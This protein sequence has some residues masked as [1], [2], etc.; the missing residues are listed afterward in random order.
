MDN[1]YFIFLLATVLVAVFFVIH[2][3]WSKIKRERADRAQLESEE[4]RMFGFLHLLGGVIE[5]GSTLDALH[6]VIVKG[7]AQVL[8]CQGAALYVLDESG[9]FLVPKAV[10]DNC[11]PMIGLPAE[12]LAKA[13]TDPKAIPSYVKLA[14]IPVGEGV[15]GG[16]VQA[17]DVVV[18]E[19][20]RDHPTAKD[21]LVRYQEKVKAMIVPLRI[22]G[23][24]IGLL[25]VANG[26]AGRVFTQ[27]DKD[28]F[29]SLAEQCAFAVRNAST[30]RLALEMRWMENDLKNASEV[31]R[32]LLPSGEPEIAGYRIV[33]VNSPARIISG[34]YYDF[35][36][37]EDKSLGVVIAD[38]SGKGVAAGLLMSMCRSVLRVIASA[39]KSSAATLAAVNRHIF[40][41]TKEDMFISM[42]YLKLNPENGSVE[43]ARAGHDAPYVFRAE[44]G[45]VEILKPK[46]LAVGI[47][48]GAV[49]ERV[50]QDF[51]FELQSGDCVLLYTD[52]LTEAENEHGE[53]FGDERVQQLFK[54]LAPLGAA[55]VIERMRK[56]WETFC[57]GR[58][59]MDDLTLIAVE[60]R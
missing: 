15:L 13:K 55:V 54:E 38:V 56:D 9:K 44:T 40:P 17:Q 21:G 18:F 4:K 41:D 29:N 46:G 31:Q 49:F 43:M 11:P 25:A 5:E 14:K 37:L 6:R 47:D 8:D 59:Q 39:E 42:A 27:N 28:V 2:A 51:G 10:S 60:K 48:E 53:E 50:T 23:E 12:T 52:G 19:D 7:A 35:I 45:E 36:Q 3:L 20:L 24:E 26:E 33:G 34:D 1:L 16:C 32:V 22:P 58:Q 30:R 57:D